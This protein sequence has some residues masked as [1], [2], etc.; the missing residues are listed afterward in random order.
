MAGILVTIVMD[1]G[2]L[3]R[4]DHAGFRRLPQASAAT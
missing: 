2:S 1:G 4:R 3:Q